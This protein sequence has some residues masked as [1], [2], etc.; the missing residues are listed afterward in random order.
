MRFHKPQFFLCRCLQVVL[1][2]I[3]LEEYA[4]DNHPPS[5]ASKLTVLNL[6]LV[7]IYYTK[8]AWYRSF[9]LSSLQ[10]DKRMS[11]FQ[12]SHLSAD[13]HASMFHRNSDC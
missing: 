11:P 3:F 5:G 12:T 9:L 4:I 2:A 6:S 7:I 8:F 1:C 10:K 13:P